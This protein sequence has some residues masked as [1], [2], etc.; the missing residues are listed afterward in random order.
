M[1]LSFRGKLKVLQ[2]SP[3]TPIVIINIFITREENFSIKWQNN[4]DQVKFIK[5]I[6]DYQQ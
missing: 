2:F 6:K 4:N 3:N 5:E 1:R